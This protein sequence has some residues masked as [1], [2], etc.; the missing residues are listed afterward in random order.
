MAR[1]WKLLLRRGLCER[2][3]SR[4]ALEAKEHLCATVSNMAQEGPKGQKF[5]IP[6]K[7]FLLFSPGRRAYRVKA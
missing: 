2:S 1:E 4:L 7:L 5:V 3:Q 6:Q